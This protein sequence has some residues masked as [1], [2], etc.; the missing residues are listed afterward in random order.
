MRVNTFFWFFT[1]LFIVTP[2]Q[3][4]LAAPQILAVLTS[5]DGVSLACAGGICEADL[6]TFCLQRARPAPGVGTEYSPAG[7]K[8]FTLVVTDASGSERRLPAS[9]YLTFSERRG[10]TAVSAH[11]P[12]G[13]L[14]ELGAVQARLEIGENASLVPVAV[15]GDKYP[16]SPEE[17]RQATG[18]LRVLGSRIVD[19]S[20]R[21]KAARVLGTMVNALPREGKEDS[22]QYEGLWTKAT[23][24]NGGTEANNAGLG[25]ARRAYDQCISAIKYR[26]TYRLRG[27]L[28]I[29][30]DKIMRDLSVKYWNAGAGS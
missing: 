21:G 18:P 24:T 13:R 4:S 15:D 30:H 7:N 5:E 9:H 29:H 8:Q 20:P 10:F 12:K 19:A 2:L 16:Q 17:I 23:V 28:A 3:G 14:A 27:C 11:M 6:S 22:T 1:F 25:Q 26:A